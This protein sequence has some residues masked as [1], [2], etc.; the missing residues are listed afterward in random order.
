[1]RSVQGLSGF[2]SLSYA[3]PER[4]KIDRMAV[5]GLSYRGLVPGRES[6]VAA[7]NVAYGHFSRE[8]AKRDRALGNP[9]KDLELVLELNY[10]IAI[11]PWLF[12][13]PDIQG[14]IHPGGSSDIDDAVVIGFAVGTVF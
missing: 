12:V 6:D 10:R 9:T 14:I 1:M 5:A 4:N 8:M 3:P 7:F 11:A 13:Q 2:L